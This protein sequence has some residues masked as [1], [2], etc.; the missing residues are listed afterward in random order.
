[1]RRDGFFSVKAADKAASLTTKKISSDGS[2]LIN[3]A[4]TDNGFAEITLLDESNTPIPGFSKKFEAGFDKV[5][6]EVFTKLP[7][8]D[9]KINIKMQN[10]E[11]YTITFK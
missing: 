10:A 5:D 11:L 7:A 2:M 3:L 8:Q 6:A 1:M 4:V 9:F